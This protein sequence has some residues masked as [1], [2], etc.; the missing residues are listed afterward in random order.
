[1]G[2]ISKELLNGLQKLFLGG[3]EAFHC[4]ILPGQTWKLKIS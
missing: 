4:L 2:G 1:M 3:N